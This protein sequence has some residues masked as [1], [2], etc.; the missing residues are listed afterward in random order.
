MLRP[1]K[2]YQQVGEWMQLSPSKIWQRDR[3]N[4]FFADG[5]GFFPLKHDTRNTVWLTSSKSTLK[6]QHLSEI[7]YV[8]MF[9]L[10]FSKIC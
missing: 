8:K 4:N 7:Q 10:Y 5:M 2:F 9:S 3:K 1:A 6:S